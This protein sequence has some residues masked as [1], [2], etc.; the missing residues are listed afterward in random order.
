MKRIDVHFGGHM[1]SLGGRAL[2]D[3]KA[4][5]QACQDAGG[6]LL[7]ND[8]EGSRRDAYL[9]LTR[10]TPIALVPIPDEPAEEG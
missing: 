10:G 5:I 9:W 7:V 2:D 6:W 1:Y 4:E 3:V 8:G